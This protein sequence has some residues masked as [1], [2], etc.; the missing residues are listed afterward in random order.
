MRA[1]VV[2]A[3]SCGV[4]VTTTK[5]DC[6]SGGEKRA[7]GAT[8]TVMAMPLRMQSIGGLPLLPVN[9]YDTWDAISAVVAAPSSAAGRSITKKSMVKLPTLAA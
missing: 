5:A 2:G 6:T 4:E 8:S 7:R 3:T 1:T 9:G